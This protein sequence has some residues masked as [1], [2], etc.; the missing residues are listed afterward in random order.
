LSKFF[1]FERELQHQDKAIL[2]IFNLVSQLQL[3]GDFLQITF[4]HL[5]EE[6]EKRKNVYYCCCV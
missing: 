1:K 4:I 5:T 6:L 3:Q 2:Q